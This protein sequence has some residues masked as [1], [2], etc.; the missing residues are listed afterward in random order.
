MTKPRSSREE[1]AELSHSF[2]Q[3]LTDDERRELFRAANFAW[4]SVQGEEPWREV[5]QPQRGQH[6]Q[7]AKISTKQ[8]DAEIRKEQDTTWE[9]ARLRVQTTA[10]AAEN[11]VLRQ[12]AQELSQKLRTVETAT[13]DDAQKQQLRVRQAEEIAAARTAD[14]EEQSERQRR[15]LAEL[16]LAAETLAKDNVLLTSEVMSLRDTGKRTER[17][18]EDLEDRVHKLQELY[19]VGLEA[20][21]VDEQSKKLPVKFW[22][23]LATPEV[24]ALSR[25]PAEWPVPRAAPPSLPNRCTAVGCREQLGRLQQATRENEALAQENKSL[26]AQLDEL[27]G[28]HGELLRLSSAE[29]KLASSNVAQQQAQLVGALRRIQWLV[30]QQKVPVLTALRA[31]PDAKLSSLPPCVQLPMPN[32][33]PYR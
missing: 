10:L 26:Q 28:A 15:V 9:L 12:G 6:Q 18:A 14:L 32:S 19:V 33:R 21:A 24:L 16:A 20:A 30:E 3:D 5:R 11:D 22:E 17:H 13:Q 31:T 1:T 8:S 7:P 4:E 27:Q 29:R 23:E 25:P 2:L